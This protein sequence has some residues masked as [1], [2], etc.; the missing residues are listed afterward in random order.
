MRRRLKT[1]RTSKWWPCSSRR[2]RTIHE[3]ELEADG[4]GPSASRRLTTRTIA[5]S[6]C[7]FGHCIP[8]T[9]THKVW[10]PC[11]EKP[12]LR[13][14]CCVGRPKAINIIPNSSVSSRMDR[15]AWRSTHISFRYMRKRRREGDSFD[16]TK[17]GPIRA[18]PRI[19]VSEGQLLHE[20][21][22]LLKK[23]SARSPALYSKWRNISSPAH[24]PHDFVVDLDPRRHGSAHMGS[25][26]ASAVRPD[27]LR[28]IIP[29]ECN[30]QG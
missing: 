4:K 12:C 26:G 28:P 18:V 1:R 10:W 19:P 6:I 20:W 7:G 16:R 14:P 30:H 13:R 5:A 25:S 17:V 9:S 3:L 11:G 22:H 24:H 2:V 8:S 23:L 29:Y 15:R 21:Q 27:S